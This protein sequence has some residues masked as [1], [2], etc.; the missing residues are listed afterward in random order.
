MRPR[1]TPPPSPIRNVAIGMVRHGRRVL[2]VQRPAAGPLPLLWE[3]PGGKIE[4]GE[5]PEAALRR[6]VREEVGLILGPCAPV[7]VLRHDY[8]HIRVRLHAFAANAPGPTVRLRGP[9]AY[10]WV[11]PRELEALPF[12][13]G[14]AGLVRRV[15]LRVG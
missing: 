10:R 5:T 2:V 9:A 15:A 6:E 14:S 3:F 13:P 12:L 11:T 4:P 7:G 1:K 8:D